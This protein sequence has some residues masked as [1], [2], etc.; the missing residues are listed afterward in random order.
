MKTKLILISGVLL[1]ASLQ[2]ATTYTLNFPSSNGYTN[3]D[4]K[5]NGSSSNNIEI[6]P[7]TGGTINSQSMTNGLIC[8]DFVDSSI[9]GNQ[10][11]YQTNVA[12]SAVAADTRFGTT[13]PGGYGAGTQLYEEM[14]WLG[15]Q[16]IQTGESTANIDAIQEAIWVM[17]YNGSLGTTWAPN[18]SGTDITSTGATY[19]Y[20][21]WITDAEADYNKTGVAGFSNLQAS[22]W[23]VVTD[24]TAAGCTSGT[25]GSTGCSTL[26]TAGTGNQ[27]Q[28]YLTYNNNGGL[29]F[30]GGSQVGTPEPASF[31]LIGSGLLAGG[32]FGRRRMKQNN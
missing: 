17:T 30:G 16:M 14:A 23:F 24:I 7:Y 9:T 4:G 11:V 3:V 27:Y 15:Q 18:G 8:D 20:S 1:G 19:S 21:Q 13:N 32:L 22:D 6:G 5:Y 2:A 31:F 26:G 28:E 25:S 10:T 29:P 12:S